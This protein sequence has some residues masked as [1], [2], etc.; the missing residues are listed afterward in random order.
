[1]P[2]YQYTVGSSKGGYVTDAKT[3]EEAREELEAHFMRP[4]VVIQESKKSPDRSGANSPG[5]ARMERAARLE[6]ATVNLEG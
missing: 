4:V 1:M 5:V 6:L 2:V 3:A